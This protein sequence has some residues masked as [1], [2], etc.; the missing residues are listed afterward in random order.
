VKREAVAL[1]VL[2]WGVGLAAIA[3]TWGVAGWTGNV[4]RTLPGWAA[5]PERLGVSPVES[6]LLGVI[7]FLLALLTWVLAR[8]PYAHETREREVRETKMVQELFHGLASVE[9]RLE[10]LESLVMQRAGRL[11][12]GRKTN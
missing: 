6:G 9:E 12:F 10:L 8:G 7:L 3:G 11:S 2:A 1:G 5:V 4:I